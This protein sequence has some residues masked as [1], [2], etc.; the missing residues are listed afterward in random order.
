M[1]SPWTVF[2]ESG[3]VRH[4]LP[5]DDAEEHIDSSWEDNSYPF[6]PVPQ[7][8]CPCHPRRE[9]EK[10]ICIFIHSSFDGR[11]GLEWANEILK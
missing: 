2:I 5:L 1:E 3:K 8:D 7:C 10:D 9:Y 11:E 6:D 4:V